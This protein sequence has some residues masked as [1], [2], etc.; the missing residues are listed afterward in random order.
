MGALVLQ[1]ALNGVEGGPLGQYQ[2]ELRAK[3][4]ARR[5]GSI[6]ATV[7]MTGVSKNTIAQLLV[8]L[9]AACS[10]G[11]DTRNILSIR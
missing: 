1:P 4:V 6:R 3:N 7:R 2:D 8:E 5:Q 10:G 11:S 9:G